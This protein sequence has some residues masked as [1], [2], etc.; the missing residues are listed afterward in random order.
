M[1]PQN[2]KELQKKPLSYNILVI[3][4]ISLLTVGS[5][6]TLE[7]YRA[8]TKT[9]VPR[10]L[11]SQIK[12]IKSKI[13]EKLMESISTRRQFTE[14]ELTNIVPFLPPDEAERIAKEKQDA[15]GSVTAGQKLSPFTN[16]T[17]PTPTATP[18]TT[19][20]TESSTIKQSTNS[21]QIAL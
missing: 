8:F 4:M 17:A 14:S 2:T 19:T 9:T 13:D 5:W 1:N 16:L 10:V 18:T 7:V 20:A 12:P 21:G 15:E 6:V 3:G 11:Q